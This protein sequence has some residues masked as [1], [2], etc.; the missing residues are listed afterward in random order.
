M[1]ILLPFTRKW[2]WRTS[3]RASAGEAEAVHHVVEPPLEQDHQALTGDPLRAI[4]LFE[5]TPE[6]SLEE[7]VHA[8]Q[9]LF[10]AQLQAVLGELHAP[11]TVL[12]GRVVPTLDGALVGVTALPLEEEL[13]T[14][15]PAE[16]A[17]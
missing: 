5:Q 9:L 6:L 16:P 15:T 8:L 2:P 11:L 4:R 10:F 13:E 12:A 1:S 17:Y 14:F 7:P 3:C